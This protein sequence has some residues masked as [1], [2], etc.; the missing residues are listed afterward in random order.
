MMM[1][2]EVLQVVHEKEHWLDESPLTREDSWPNIQEEVAVIIDKK[3]RRKSWHAI[4]FE[5]KR[6]KG[7]VDPNTPPE[8]RQKRPSWWN[9]FGSS[10]WPR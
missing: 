4:K 10:Q 1:N 9:I 3:A 7:V 8:A 2:T 5:R 6:R